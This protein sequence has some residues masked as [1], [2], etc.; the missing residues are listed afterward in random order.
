MKIAGGAGQHVPAHAKT[1][2][3]FGVKEKFA[4]EDV[5]GSSYFVKS[6]NDS[7]LSPLNIAC[8]RA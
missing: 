5:L 3:V 1:L 6:N 8:L 4:W 7:P 2:L